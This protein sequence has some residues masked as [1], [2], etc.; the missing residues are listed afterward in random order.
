MIIGW[1]EY[2]SDTDSYDGMIQAAPGRASAL[3]CLSPGVPSS[4]NAPHYRMAIQRPESP[5]VYVGMAWKCG[6]MH[7][8]A[9]LA[10]CIYD[11]GLPEPVYAG[12]LPLET[13]PFA[14]LVWSRSNPISPSLAE[15]T[16]EALRGR[17]RDRAFAP[18]RAFHKAI[19]HV[20]PCCGRAAPRARA[21]PSGTQQENLG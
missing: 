17:H 8:R 15:A 3:A 18:R 2:D 16:V 21:R 5:L 9:I 14:D 6:T 20:A 11:P 10:V 4:P 13:G 19:D 1:F 12:L 7:H